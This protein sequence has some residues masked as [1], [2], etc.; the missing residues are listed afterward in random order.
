[1]LFLGVLGI[2]RSLSVISDSC[3]EQQQRVQQYLDALKEKM[4]IQSERKNINDQFLSESLWYL[5]LKA[6]G[7]NGYDDYFSDVDCKVLEIFRNA[8]KKDHCVNFSV[9][10]KNVSVNWEVIMSYAWR[11]DEFIVML[12]A[13]LKTILMY[14]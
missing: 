6:T 2:L 1:M 5:L 4:E 8:N 7:F 11:H 13:L 12:T 14:L 3:E 10:G 9:K